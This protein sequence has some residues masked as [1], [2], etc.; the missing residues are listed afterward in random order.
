MLRVPANQRSHIACAGEFVTLEADTLIEIT[1]NW[2]KGIHVD[3]PGESRNLLQER[4]RG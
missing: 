2:L 1:D 3:R 4:L